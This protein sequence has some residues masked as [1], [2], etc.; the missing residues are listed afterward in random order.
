MSDGDEPPLTLQSEPNGSS[1]FAPP[2]CS[3]S[4]SSQLKNLWSL[5]VSQ[6]AVTNGRS[7]GRDQNASNLPAKNA[8]HTK[9]ICVHLRPSAVK[10]I[11]RS[12]QPVLVAERCSSPTRAASDVGIANSRRPPA[13]GAAPL[14]GTTGGVM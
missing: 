11:L 3:A 1:P 9:R 7:L 2:I 6:T 8:K 5:A 10:K 4:Q 12:T 13:F 14:F